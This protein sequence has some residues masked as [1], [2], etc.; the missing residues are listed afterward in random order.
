MRER[1]V[2]EYDLIA[3]MLMELA[4]SDMGKVL[5]TE[6][7]PAYEQ[8]SVQRLQQETSDALA[9]LYK[10][11][12]N[13]IAAFDDMRLPLSRG[14]KGSVLTPAELLRISQGLK[15]AREARAALE[16]SGEGV[17]SWSRLLNAYPEIEEVITRSILSEEEIADSASSVLADIRRKIR[18]AH[19]RIRE[20]LNGFIHSQTYQKYLQEPIITIRNDRYV[21]PVRQEYRAQVPGMLH[22]A[23]A[24]GA[25]LFIEPM[26][27]VEINNA[28]KSLLAEEKGEIERILAA[29]TSMVVPCAQEIT[30]NL[31][32]LAQLDRIFAK[33][34]LARDMKALQPVLNQSRQFRLTG[35]RHPLISKEQVVPID[36][37]IQEEIDGLLIT[38]P[39]TGGKTVTLKTLGLFALM[40]Q[41]G[42]HLPTRQAASM[43][44]FSHVFADIGDEQSIE[45]SLSTFSSHMTNIIEILSK[46][47]AHS[48]VL[49]DEL[50]AGTDPTE[51]AALGMAIIDELTAKGCM[52]AAT[53]HYSELKEYALVKPRIENA[54]MEFDIQTLQPTYKLLMGVAGHSNA[55]EIS[56][57]LGLSQRVIQKAREYVSKEDA[58]FEEA[59]KNAQKQQSQA[60]EDRERAETE[61]QKSNQALKEAGHIRK[62][63]QAQHALILEKAREQAKQIMQKAAQEA[64][65]ILDEMKKTAKDSPDREYARQLKRELTKKEQ[66]YAPVIERAAYTGEA[67]KTLKK[68]DM[69]TVLSLNAKGIVLSPPAQGKEAR[70]QVGVMKM[71]VPLKDLRLAEQESEKKKPPGRSGDFIIRSVPG[72]LHVRMQTLDEALL[73]LDRY[74]D[75]A[76][77]AGRETVRIVHGKGTGVLR[78]GIQ[79]YLRSHPH[80][81]SFRLGQ[82]GEGEAGVTVV[83]LK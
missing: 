49:L 73:N 70:V 55:F 20:K 36:I 29:I 39:N 80:V 48:L 54:S 7:E 28:L 79:Q 23:S 74:L 13:P 27:V 25:T 65:H 47:D 37:V 45:Q 44:V 6:L 71:N 38:G 69:V 26:A 11:G 32:I 75:D 56:R 8:E 58:R 67:P 42:L 68:G 9:V 62:E 72:E 64:E 34:Q 66:A 78:N 50:G 63:A 15:V 61:R 12:Y 53:T 41:S 33:A 17:A 81:K 21:I 46:A 35:A 24:S 51:G 40:A 60:K 16:E 83:E 31:E 1:R 22:D 77:L 82:Y 4:V 30:S 52:F 57:R 18:R 14:V 19:E 5:C 10:A 59:L 2:L 3:S 43:C 76:F